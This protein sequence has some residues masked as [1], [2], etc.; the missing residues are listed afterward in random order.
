[1]ETKLGENIPA[2]SSTRA[3]KPK[4]NGSSPKNFR[5]VGWKQANFPRGL[6]VN[7]AKMATTGH[8]RNW[9]RAGQDTPR[10]SVE[11]IVDTLI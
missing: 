1:M 8:S 6:K 11:F 4:P 2:S 7:P 5:G 9:Q 10:P 3:L